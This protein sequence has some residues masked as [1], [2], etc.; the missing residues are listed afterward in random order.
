MKTTLNICVFLWV[1]AY[2]FPKAFPVLTKYPYILWFAIV[3]LSIL[4]PVGFAY[5][6]KGYFDSNKKTLKS[7]VIPT[8]YLGVFLSALIW[9]LVTTHGL[10]S[11]SA[12]PYMSDLK[13][14]S[15]LTAAENE[16]SRLF[17]ART[18]YEEYGQ[19]VAYK[20]SNDEFV[21][22]EPKEEDVKKY[23]E[24]RKFNEE[25][26]KLMLNIGAQAR[27]AMNISLVLVGLF[28]ILFV[29]ALIY[30]QKKR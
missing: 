15:G 7:I 29:S 10:N 19:K 11:L 20:N 13:L 28:F 25:S 24:R 21:I 6:L 23:K 14:I 2:F 27:S 16:E 17:W 26:E 9:P 4:L 3:L 1:F 18:L 8:S 22:F 5:S 30:I 12:Y